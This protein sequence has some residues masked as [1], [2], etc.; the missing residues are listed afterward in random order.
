MVSA[1]D[2]V[3]NPQKIQEGRC[4]NREGGGSFTATLRA[5][6]VLV[7]SFPP[8]LPFVFRG[9][10]TFLVG[11]LSLNCH[12]D[13]CP[14]FCKSC[15]SSECFGGSQFEFKFDTGFEGADLEEFWPI[16]DV[17]GSCGVIE[18]SSPLRGVRLTIST[19]FRESVRRSYRTIGR[20]G[21]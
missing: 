2:R 20:A 14:A 3:R 15:E 6:K 1:F 18:E 8:S 7:F 11:V 10:G 5:R 12:H 13:K 4:S 21:P 9:L 17:C 19:G 16:V